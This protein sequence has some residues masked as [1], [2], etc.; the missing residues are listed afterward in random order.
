M[1]Y[2]DYTLKMFASTII[3]EG[4]S[5]NGSTCY[6]YL[7]SIEMLVKYKLYSTLLYASNKKCDNFL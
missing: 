6:S 3:M 7:S 2:L 4:F 1:K 5:I